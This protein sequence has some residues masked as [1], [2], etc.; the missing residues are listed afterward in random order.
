[1]TENPVRTERRGHVLEVTLDRPKA[2]AIDLATSRIMGEVF[3]DFRDDPDCRVA[4]LA[5]TG[6]DAFC[7]GGD[8]ELLVPLLEGRREP[9]DELEARFCR[10]QA[11][12]QEQAFL[13]P[14]DLDKPIVAA[15]S[16]DAV[17]GGC[18]LMLGSD[19]RVASSEAPWS[20]RRRCS[21]SRLKP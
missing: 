9:A 14:F 10:D 17:A 1:M 8:T 4:V 15:L 20:A 16:G 11:T 5:G 12:L 7:A 13:N 18:E 3:R 19:I 2:N 21:K 6:T